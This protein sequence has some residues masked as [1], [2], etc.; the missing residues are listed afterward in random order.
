MET[1]LSGSA[2]RAL[3]DQTFSKGVEDYEREDVATT[4]D[5]M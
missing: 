3:K 1:L 2:Q 5:P 4:V